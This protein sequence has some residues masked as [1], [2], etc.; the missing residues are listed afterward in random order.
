MVNQG[1]ASIDVEEKYEKFVAELRTDR[2]VTAG[3]PFC[4]PLCM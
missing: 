2:Y 4:K 3:P 1:V